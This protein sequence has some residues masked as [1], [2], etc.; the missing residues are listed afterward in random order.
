MLRYAPND[1]KVSGRTDER[2]EKHE[3][4]RYLFGANLPRLVRDALAD[5]ERRAG[6]GS[7]EAIARRKAAP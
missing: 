1:G 7:A 5:R 6:P 4:I 3:S 2:G